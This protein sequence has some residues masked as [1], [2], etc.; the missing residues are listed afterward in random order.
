M[1]LIPRWPAPGARRRTPPQRRIAAVAVAALAAAFLQ[2]I[3]A[4]AETPPA[5]PSDAKLAAAPARHDDTREQFYFVMPDRFAN[6]D[7]SND[8]GGLTGSRLAT[9]YDPYHYAVP[10]GSY[11]TDP[12]GTGR[13]EF[14]EMVKSLNGDGLRVVMDVVYNH[15]A[16]SGQADTSVLD[17]VVPGYYQRLLADGS[18]ATSTLTCCANTATGVAVSLPVSTSLTSV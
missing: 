7:T 6:G 12:D 16:A 5:P 13:V 11:A 17:R 18:V 14:R 9:G 8:R 2:P 3:A 4:R 1:A 10:R 15:T